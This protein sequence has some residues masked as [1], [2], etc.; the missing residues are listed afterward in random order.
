MSKSDI[1]P[2]WIMH[3]AYILDRKLVH[4]GESVMLA[5]LLRAKGNSR[6]SDDMADTKKIMRDQ[7][8]R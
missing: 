1:N 4:T 5:C 8:I 6:K 7:N 2:N 3:R